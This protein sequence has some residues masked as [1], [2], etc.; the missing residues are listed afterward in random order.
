VFHLVLLLALQFPQ[1]SLVGTVRDEATGIPIA[2]ALVSLPDLGRDTTTDAGGRYVLS[3]V[4]P[5]PQHVLIRYIGYTQHALHALVPPSGSL[6]IDVALRAQPVRL[7]T[8]QVRS[9]PSIRGL[10]PRDS[11]VLADR[12][13][14]MA[15]IRNHPVLASPT[16][17]R[18]S[19]GGR[20]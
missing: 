7:G 17:S 6:E 8:I 19:A 14:S 1:A 12:S 13:V 18:D 2:G 20:S 9:P 3:D 11:S 10:E 16:R 5:G 15:A 4:P